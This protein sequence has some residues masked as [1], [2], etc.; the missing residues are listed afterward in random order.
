MT[1]SAAVAQVMQQMEQEGTYQLTQQ[2]NSWMVEIKQVIS[3]LNA[4]IFA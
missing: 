4:L 1:I 3:A 2:M